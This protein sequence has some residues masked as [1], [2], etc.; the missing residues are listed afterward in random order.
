M[1]WFGLK[2]TSPTACPDEHCIG[3][4][5]DGTC[6]KCQPN[7]VVRDGMCVAW[8]SFLCHGDGDETVGCLEC[9]NGVTNYVNCNSQERTNSCFYTNTT[10]D[11]SFCLSLY[12]EEEAVTVPSRCEIENGSCVVCL[13][14][15]YQHFDEIT[16][17]PHCEPCG[18]NCAM[19][20]ATRCLACK[21]G[22]NFT[23]DRTV[24][25][26]PSAKGTSHRDCGT[27]KVL[28]DGV[29]QDCPGGCMSCTVDS[30]CILCEPSSVVLNGT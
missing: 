4:S 12:T 21:R 26:D 10:P 27:A 18:A 28:R 11:G 17:T 16:G 30:T 1:C 3:C 20:N 24:C 13:D 2:S 9:P 6:V 8:S 19:C 23:Q 22:T 29:G 15:F 25:V 7:Y 5:F 14:G